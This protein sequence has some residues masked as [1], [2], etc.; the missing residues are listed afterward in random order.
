MPERQVR[1]SLRGDFQ[2][3]AILVLPRLLLRGRRR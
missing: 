3:V 1:L 2:F